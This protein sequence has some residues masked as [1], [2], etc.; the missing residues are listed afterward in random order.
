MFAGGS[1]DR[2]ARNGARARKWELAQTYN[3]EDAARN[4][5]TR[6]EVLTDIALNATGRCIN[7]VASNKGATE[8]VMLAILGNFPTREMRVRL[9]RNK[10]TPT[11]ILDKIYPDP[12][13]EGL[14]TP[15]LSHRNVSKELLAKNLPTSFSIYW[16][17]HSH[18]RAAVTNPS[19]PIELLYPTADFIPDDKIAAKIKARRPELDD[20]FMKEYNVDSS[21]LPHETVVHLLS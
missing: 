8:K 20:Y 10:S 4:I 15:I 5:N 7:M 21:V 19:V 13:D 16:K 2:S 14:R 12:V 1:L 9:A 11:S 6:E 18:V 17:W 3:V